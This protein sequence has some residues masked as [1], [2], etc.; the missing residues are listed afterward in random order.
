M[1]LHELLYIL[2]KFS[3]DSAL[4]YFPYKTSVGS[5]FENVY[6]LTSAGHPLLRAVNRRCPTVVAVDFSCT[7]TTR[8]FAVLPK[9]RPS[10]RA[11]D[12]VVLTCAHRSDL[13]INTHTHTHTH[14]HTQRDIL[15]PKPYIL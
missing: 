15:G 3:K 14:T 6:T 5:T 13:Y 2:H 10:A 1:P 11:F 8:V 9:S 7:E 4:V 12:M